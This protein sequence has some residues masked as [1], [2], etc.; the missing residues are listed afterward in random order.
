MSPIGSSKTQKK[1]IKTVNI[2]IRIPQCYQSDSIILNLV[3]LYGLTININSA[4]LTEGSTEGWFDLDLRGE[5]GA[6]EAALSYLNDFDL[7]TWSGQTLLEATL[8]RS[9]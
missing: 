3:S 6:I 5:A 8:L 2:K 4:L 7:G 1:N 9:F